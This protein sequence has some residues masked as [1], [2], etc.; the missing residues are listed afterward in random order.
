MNFKDS[1]KKKFKN[2]KTMDSIRFEASKS[3]LVL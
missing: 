3:I 1:L 2:K